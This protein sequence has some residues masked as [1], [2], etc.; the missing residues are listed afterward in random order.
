MGGESEET[1]AQDIV[2]SRKE[3]VT[4]GQEQTHEILFPPF[5]LGVHL[6]PREK[7]R[8]GINDPESLKGRTE[9]ISHKRVGEVGRR[10]VPH[11]AALEGDKVEG[12]R[13]SGSGR[14]T[15]LGEIQGHSGSGG[16][17]GSRGHGGSG[18]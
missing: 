6:R 4:G 5:L 12:Q 8:R 9:P 11:R 17:G 2:C 3:T 7:R 18:S 15:A 10:Q 16:H 13:S 1:A 14:H